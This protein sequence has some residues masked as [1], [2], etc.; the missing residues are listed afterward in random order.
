VQSNTTLTVLNETPYTPLMRNMG[1]TRRFTQDKRGKQPSKDKVGGGISFEPQAWRA[2]QGTH[3]FY[4][5]ASGF[6]AGAST[7]ISSAQDM[8][9]R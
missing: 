8:T 2:P 7:Q 4:G 1:G 6:L 3:M 5:R 9:R